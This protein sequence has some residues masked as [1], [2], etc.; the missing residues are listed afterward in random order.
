MRQSDHN[1]AGWYTKVK[2]I[3]RQI[4]LSQITQDRLDHKLAS[5]HNEGSRTTM[6]FR[7]TKVKIITRPLNHTESDHKDRFDHKA[8]NIMR[9][10]RPQ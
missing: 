9:A 4:T 2:I 7:S 1:E 10:V 6:R 5:K 3:M 8:A